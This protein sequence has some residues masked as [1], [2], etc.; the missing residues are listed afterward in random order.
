LDKK[1]LI[2]LLL[3]THNSTAQITAFRKL[4]NKQTSTARHEP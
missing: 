4:M 1:D 2:H 3:R